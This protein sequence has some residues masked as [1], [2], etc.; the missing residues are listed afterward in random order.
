LSLDFPVMARSCQRASRLVR[1]HLAPRSAAIPDISL[2]ASAALPGY[3]LGFG[4]DVVCCVGGTSLSAPY[5]AGI[6]A[7]APQKGA[8]AR[9]GN[10]NQKL[11][12]LGPSGSFA[13]DSVPCRPRTEAV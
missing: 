2:R 7:L 5:W 11:Y 9:S 3:F 6:S 10:L 12:D 8:A 13:G 1:R 4:T